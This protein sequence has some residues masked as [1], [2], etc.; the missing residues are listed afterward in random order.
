MTIREHFEDLAGEAYGG[1]ISHLLGRDPAYPEW[2]KAADLQAAW[3]V[4][5][6]GITDLRNSNRELLEALE[7]LTTY[8][9]GKNSWDRPRPKFM[10]MARAAI[11]KARK[12]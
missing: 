11:A 12:P 9:D 2:Y 10:M 1:D 6:A 5:E 3:R 4:F 8:F 7:G